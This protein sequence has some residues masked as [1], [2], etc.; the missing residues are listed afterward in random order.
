M[1]LKV[2]TDA[3]LSQFVIGAGVR[4]SSNKDGIRFDLGVPVKPGLTSTEAEL[5]AML[6]GIDAVK[7]LIHCH[8]IK[9]K[10]EVTFYTDCESAFR[11]IF[12]ASTPRSEATKTLAKKVRKSLDRAKK[13]HFKSWNLLTVKSASN[14]AD[15]IARAARERWRSIWKQNHSQG[16]SGRSR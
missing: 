1:K 3:S 8:K 10:A 9:R 16:T 4:I 15:K 14:Q 13:T 12:G 2:F 11:F 7:S 5:Y 6:I